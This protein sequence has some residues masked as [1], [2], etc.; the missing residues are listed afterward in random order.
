KMK[1]YIQTSPHDTYDRDANQT[2]ILIDGDYQGQP[3]K[4]LAMASR[5]GYYFLLDRATGESL[6]TVP[7]GSQN[8]SA[9][10]DKRGQ[11]ITKTEIDA[12]L[13][14]TR[15]N[16]W[17]PSFSPETGLFYVNGSHGFSIGYLMPNEETG[18]VE[19]HQGGGA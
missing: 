9:G 14:G 4:L 7:Y 3:R 16:W 1:W 13:E 12:A 11:P 2:P 6:V 18:N 19:D 10:V 17:A 5:S 15:T 8:W